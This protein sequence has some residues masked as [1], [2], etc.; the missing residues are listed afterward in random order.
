M[1]NVGKPKPK[2]K[3][4]ELQFEGGVDKW[5]HGWKGSQKY[6]FDLCFNMIKQSLIDK[7][8]V[9]DIGCA[10]GDFTNRIYEANTDSY[11]HGIDI[12][13]NA[14]KTVKKLYP[15]IHFEVNKLPNIRTFRDGSFDLIT[16][17]EIIGYLDNEDVLKSFKKIHKLLKD[18]GLFLFSGKFDYFD[19]ND[20]VNCIIDSGFEI[21]NIRYY[22]CRLYKKIESGLMKRGRIAHIILRNKHIP[23][24][25]DSLSKLFL[26]EG[27][28]TH[29]FILAKKVEEEDE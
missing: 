23:H 3:W 13:E 25:L 18:D 15:E 6:R 4:F 24:F 17:L 5:G 20:I 28:K 12:S 9:L 8:N 11:V 10:L 2:K 16:A 7:K 19:E 27:G 29:I 26:W 22:H 1:T 21:V 14:I